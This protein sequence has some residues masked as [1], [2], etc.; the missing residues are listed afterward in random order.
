MARHLTENSVDDL[1]LEV[2]SQLFNS[3]SVIFPKKGEAIELRAVTLELDNPRA[4]LSRT[5]TRGRLFSCLGE[6]CW[7]LSGS[8]DLEA[9]AYYLPEYRKFAVNNRVPSA[10]GP[11]LR[12]FDG[13]DQLLNIAKML[14]EHSVTRQAVIQIFDHD[15]LAQGLGEVPC[16]CTLQFLVRNG[17]LELIVYMR[18]NDAYLGL[19]HDFFAFTMIQ[20]LIARLVGAEL[21]TYTHIVGSLHLYTKDQGRARECMNE[22]WQSNVPMPAMPSTN[23]LEGLDWLL[24]VE[25][26][27]RDADDPLQIDLRGPNDYWSDLAC[28]LAIFGLSRRKRISDIPRLRDSLHAKEYDLYIEERLNQ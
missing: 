18:S 4:R 11:R 7:Y 23:P 12:S 21:G 9:I 26:Q 14:S 1:I 10:Y 27:I 5:E 16:T 24:M 13:F 17:A 2:F 28:L 3:G 25:R 15:D 6:L 22:G 8:A 19:P 20:E